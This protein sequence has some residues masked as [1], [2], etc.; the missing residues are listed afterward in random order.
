MQHRMKTHQLDKRQRDMLLSSRQVGTI[1]TIN[2][3]GTPYC[4]PVHFVYAD[5]KIYIHGLPAGQKIDNLI[6]N[7]NVCLSVYNMDCLLL[8]ENGVPCDT[9]TKYQSAVIQGTAKIVSDIERKAE[10]LVYI[11]AKYTPNLK[12]VPLATAMVKG[13]AVTEIEISEITGKYW[14]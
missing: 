14:E 10:I 5:G 13:T 6:A 11:V 4:V 12:D 3:D 1:A 8:D 2:K 9:N 7:P